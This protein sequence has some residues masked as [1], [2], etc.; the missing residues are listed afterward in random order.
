MH[1]QKKSNIE[2]TYILYLLSRKREDRISPFLDNDYEW[3][4]LSFKYEG[5]QA[6][7]NLVREC[8]ITL[9]LDKHIIQLFEDEISENVRNKVMALL[10]VFMETSESKFD[11]SMIKH[12]LLETRLNILK[13]IL[14]T[15]D[16]MEQRLNE[17]RYLYEKDKA[18][19]NRE[20]KKY[21]SEINHNQ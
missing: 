19:F 17:L 20:L 14:H 6:A 9:W 8:Y 5:N 16:N 1:K 2:I 7:F 4:G 10:S 21:E 15:E 11:D 12:T 18:L 3:I 13:S